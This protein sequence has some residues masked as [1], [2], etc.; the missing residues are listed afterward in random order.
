MAEL[1]RRDFPSFP[2]KL[3]LLLMAISS[4]GSAVASSLDRLPDLQTD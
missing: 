4:A 3:A 2:I 1:M